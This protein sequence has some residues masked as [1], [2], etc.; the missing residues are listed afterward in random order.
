MVAVVR[1]S[2]SVVRSAKAYQTLI[3]VS[4]QRGISASAW[5]SV[6]L[7]DGRDGS[8]TGKMSMAFASWIPSHLGFRIQMSWVIGYC[9]TAV[10][11]V[12]NHCI[13]FQKA[14]A[15]T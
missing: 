9:V 5:T 14:K 6:K 12:K 10:K 3:A 11:A 4:V 1:K 13:A 7:D 2:R 15:M 8:R